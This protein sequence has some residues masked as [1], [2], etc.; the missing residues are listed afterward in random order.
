MFNR[1]SGLVASGA[2]LLMQPM[3][4]L[5]QQAQPPAAPASTPWYW[6]GPWLMWGDGSGWSF[7]WL[8]PLMMLVMMAVCA[9]MF[10][11]HRA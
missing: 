2:V 3:A 1:I 11:R 7:W 4:V 5:A 10:F 9:A 8:C 6:P